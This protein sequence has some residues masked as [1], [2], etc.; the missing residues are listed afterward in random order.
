MVEA[1]RSYEQMNEDDLKRLRQLSLDTFDDVSTRCPVA[2][3][4]RGRLAL[5]S[6]CQGAGQHF[7][8]HTNGVKH[9]DV[10]AFFSS[11]PSKPFPAR[12]IWHADFWPSRFGRHPDDLG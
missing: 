6:L 4:Y 1:D 2:G 11:G 12:A 5:L 8:D 3:L 10:W 7:V 9:F